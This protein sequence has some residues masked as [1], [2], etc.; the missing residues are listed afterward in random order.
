MDRFT[1]AAVAGVVL[2]SV[3]AIVV[4][5]A[6][7]G[8]QQPPDL[9]TPQGVVAAYILAVQDKRADDAWAMLESPSAVEA[10]PSPAGQT[11]TRETFRQQVNNA[12]QNGDRR[13]R[14]VDTKEQADGVRVDVEITT[15]TGGPAIFGSDSYS[16]SATFILVRSDSSWRIRSSPP[17]WQLA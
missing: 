7:R 3:V 14:I 16:R 10:V 6:P 11:M 12:Q 17:I 5:V 13:L 4:A 1:W 15:F 8:E 2:L 9:T